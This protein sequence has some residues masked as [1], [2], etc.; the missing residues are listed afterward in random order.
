MYVCVCMYVCMYVCMHACI[1]ACMYVCINSSDYW[2][3]FKKVILCFISF[4]IRR[5]LC[6]SDSNYSIGVTKTVSPRYSCLSKVT[7][8]LSRYH[9][10]FSIVQGD[11]FIFN[12]QLDYTSDLLNCPSRVFFL[13]WLFLFKTL[14]ANVFMHRIHVRDHDRHILRALSWIS[15]THFSNSNATMWP[16]FSEIVG[17]FSYCEIKF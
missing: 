12:W 13:A 17:C 9:Q 3:W 4:L 11:H 14:I 5:F 7:S 6:Q 1:H 15:G 16:T 8:K 2:H 10:Q